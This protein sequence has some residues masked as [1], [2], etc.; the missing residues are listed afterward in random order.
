MKL[1][2]GEATKLR[3]ISIFS[4][5]VTTFTAFLPIGWKFGGM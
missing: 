1:T 5:Y 4:Y 3:V 2:M